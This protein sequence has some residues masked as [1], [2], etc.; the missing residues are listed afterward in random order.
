MEKIVRLPDGTGVRLEGRIVP[1]AWEVHTWSA[2]GVLERSA[3]PVVAWTEVGEVPPALTDEEHRAFLADLYHGEPAKLARALR[4]LDEE[5]EERRLKN[6][7]RAA[8]RAKTQCRRAI[9]SEKFNEMLTLTYRENQTDRTLAQK[10][11]KEWCRRMRKALGVFRFCAS[12]EPQDRGAWHIHCATHKLPTVAQ[13]RGMKVKAWEVGTRIWRDIV[14]A[15]N[16]LCYVGGRSKFGAPRAGRLSL[17]KMASYV[18][19][20]ILKTFED[21]APGANRYQ[22]S[23]GA[24]IPKPERMTFYGCTLLDLLN[25]VYEQGPGVVVHSFKLSRWKD[26]VWFCNECSPDVSLQSP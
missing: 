2:S 17:A 1:D 22:R 20:Y 8:R 13:Y 18:S 15:D 3:R 23:I 10:H 11:F 5:A 16:G 4:E 21:H 7:Q 9:V 6:L 26:S 12:F 25:L 24:P 14:G 19:K